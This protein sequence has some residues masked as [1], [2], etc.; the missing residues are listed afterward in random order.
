MKQRAKRLMAL[1]MA[2][3]FALSTCMTSGPYTV[4]ATEAGTAGVTTPSE[5]T[6]TTPSQGSTTT[7]D[8]TTPSGTPEEGGTTDP[9]PEAPTQHIYNVKL[10]EKIKDVDW[11][12]LQ[13]TYG[14]EKVSVTA[15]NTIALN[16]VITDSSAV[17]IKSDNYSFADITV[18]DGTIN[19]A[20]ATPKLSN[21][22]VKGERTTLSIDEK[23]EYS[24]SNI[25][26]VWKDK[27]T[28]SV[29]PGAEN[30]TTDGVSLEEQEDHTKIKVIVSKEGYEGANEK[31]EIL[32]AHIGEV[33]IGTFNFNVTKKNPELSLK[34]NP[35]PPAG[36][37]TEIKLL[38]SGQK[39][40]NKKVI[41]SDENGQTQEVAVK[42]GKAEEINWNLSY[43]TKDY[44]FVVTYAG[45]KVYKSESISLAYNVDKET[46]QFEL[47]QSAEQEDIT[48]GGSEK[49][50]ASIAGTKSSGIHPWNYSYEWENGNNG[51]AAIRVDG[52]KLLFTPGQAGTYKVTI[53][54]SSEDYN[55]CSCTLA[56]TVKKKALTVKNVTATNRVY[57][58]TDKVEVTAAVDTSEI[59]EKDRPAGESL[60]LTT[61][62]KVQGDGK[63]EGKDVADGKT[64]KYG[65]E[66]KDEYGQEYGDFSL[67]QELNSNYEL[68]YAD[69]KKPDVKVNIT[70]QKLTLAVVLAKPNGENN[71]KE[72]ETEEKIL[73][74]ERQ[75]TGYK[76][77][78]KENKSKEIQVV[79]T[80]FVNGES[81]ETLT[82]YQAPRVIV[83][84]TVITSASELNHVYKDALIPDENKTDDNLYNATD[85]YEFDFGNITQ[86]GSLS[87]TPQK[88]ADI[89]AILSVDNANSK[90]AYQR[91]DNKEIYYGEISES[92]NDNPKIAWKIDNQF[93]SNV[94]DTSDLDVTYNAVEVRHQIDIDISE[95]GASLSYSPKKNDETIYVRLKASEGN[96]VTEW[97]SLKLCF[98]ETV[99]KAKITME[100]KT[101]MYKFENVI[102]FGLFV[103]KKKS[104]SAKIDLTDEEAGVKSWKYYKLNLTEDKEFA[105]GK[106]FIDYVKN[107]LPTETGSTTT[108]ESSVTPEPLNLG[109]DEGNYVVFAVVEDNVGNEA[110]Y[111]SNGVIIDNT[112]PQ[113]FELLY[114]GLESE[115]I[116]N[117]ENEALKNVDFIKNKNA[118]SL[119][120]H[121]KEAT[122]VFSGISKIT[123]NVYAENKEIDK[124]KVLYE[125][126]NDTA[127]TLNALKNY[128][129]VFTNSTDNGKI[130]QKIASK[131]ECVRYRVDAT[132]G[133]K[134]GNEQTISKEF[135]LDTLPPDITN[136]NIYLTNNSTEAVKTMGDDENV[137]YYSNEDVTIKTTV[138]ERFTDSNNIWLT[139][140]KD[141]VE[142]S[143]TLQQWIDNDD[144]DETYSVT[145]EEDKDESN[146]NASNR[147]IEFTVQADGLENKFSYYVSAKDYSGN[148]TTND[149]INFVID[150]VSPEISDNIIRKS[151]EDQKNNEDHFDNKA[152]INTKVYYSNED[153]V[154][155][156]EVKDRFIDAK[157]IT[158]SLTKD[159]KEY[160]K[161]VEEWCENKD[162]KL[163]IKCTYDDP[164]KNKA[165]RSVKTITFN[166]PE[167]KNEGDFTYKVSAVDYANNPEKNPNQTIN[168]CID[169]TQPEVEVTYSPIQNGEPLAPINTSNS[170]Y[171][172]NQNYDSFKVNI[173]V[174]E[175]HLKANDKGTIISNYQLSKDLAINTYHVTGD[176]G[177]KDIKNV[178]VSASRKGSDS[179]VDL[180]TGI[181]ADIAGKESWLENP[182]NS[183]EY[184][185]TFTCKKE[186]NYE[187]PDITITDLAGN[188]SEATG[189]AKITLD[190][191]AP[192]GKIKVDGLIST[193]GK[194]TV[195]DRLL[196]SLTFGLYGKDPVTATIRNRDEKTGGSGIA[197]K[198]Y[199]LATDLMSRSALDALKD[200]QWTT[201]NGNITMPA[202][203]SY[204]VYEKVVDKAGNLAYYSSDRVIVD[205]QN[206]QPEV[207]ITPTTPGWG[208]GVYSASDNPGFD[209][210]V[211]DPAGSDG[212]CA[213][214]AEINCTITDRTTGHSKPI[215]LRSYSATSAPEATF[216]T[217]VSIDPA[218][219]YSNEVQV[220][221]EAK[222]HSTNPAT[223]ESQVIKIDN[224]API[225][226]FSFDKSDVHNG[227]YYNNDKTLTITVDERNFD[228]S[229]KPQV[230]STAGGGYSI[231]GWSHNGEI[232]T[233]TVTF[234]GDSDYTVTYD[235]YDLAGNKSNT[236]KLEEFT[237]DKTKPAIQV[238]Y[239]NNNAL[240]NNYYKDA[241]TATITITEHNF[242]PGEVTV[243]TTAQLDGAP[244]A[245]P[246]VSGWSG[247]GDTHVATVSY[248]A[249]ADYTFTISATDLA[250]NVSE[251]YVTD[252]FTVDQTKPTV[253]ITNIEDHSANNGEVAP[254]VTLN[255]INFD[256]SKT[257][258]HLTGANKGEIDTTGMYTSAATAKGQTLTFHNFAENMDDIYTLTAEAT[259]KAGNVYSTSK[260]FSVNRDGSTYMYDSYTDELIKNG[261][262]NDPKNLVVSEINVDTLTFQELT[263]TENGT[264][265]TLEQDK[266]Y[267]VQ[268]SGSEVS[269][270]EYKYTINASNFEEEGDYNVSIYSEDRA[271]NVT[272]NTSKSK[273]ILFAVDKTS[274]VIAL[275]NIEDGGRYKVESQKF[276]ANVDDN[277]A[278]DKVEYY[279]DGKLQQTFD[280]SEVAEQ[281][282]SL[283]LS[284]DSSSKF[285]K[286][287]VKAY[288]KANN[289]ATSADADVLVSASSWVQFYNN[290]PAFYGT[291]GGGVA[292]LA[293]AVAAGVHFSGA[294]AAAGTAGAAGAGGFFF[295]AGK[296]KKDE[297]ETK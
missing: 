18:N 193:N 214:L 48:Y 206:P 38:V 165:E 269:W 161:S 76:D 179:A 291:I 212:S 242:N 255:D 62:G 149:A 282:G 258:V 40:F 180:K 202:N 295:L 93:N 41:V 116:N 123:A 141:G 32:V 95:E 79:A 19:V 77:L 127:L 137:T 294:G 187:F 249:D 153:V 205:A 30:I 155:K 199:Y 104:V 55:E 241:R 213:G 264:L 188:K 223:V 276:T 136:N 128:E 208:K 246:G 174:I 297:E 34:A 70:K 240:N 271:T 105:D 279:V 7:P 10:P 12:N 49:Q 178:E 267:E 270:K 173:K 159:K 112:E 182:K 216:R 254:V 103:N 110:V 163:G 158:I 166:V 152:D 172:L 239:D 181:I 167:A 162:S 108:A 275:S 138:T 260:M 224:K 3:V 160:T 20:T 23:A 5:G 139:I 146:P 281:S 278:L 238:S 60:Q 252:N 229:Y 215:P 218:E 266:D 111:G 221:V 126:E 289:E 91:T 170:I 101:N 14:E 114:E 8:N 74:L 24:I 97:C 122:T 11:G 194:D 99:P 248:S 2:G 100:D 265:K 168:F 228:E 87:L 21:P 133:D 118:V 233:A 125:E 120:A 85:N 71:I 234:S 107:V 28:W 129:E 261:Y 13:V 184:N 175:K 169:T 113:I 43:W 200:E 45:D 83:D 292:V 142:T 22:E 115:D 210:Y 9:E 156:T 201:Y 25:P 253:E 185:Y 27:V 236:E 72:T 134:A 37:K 183:I 82:G 196:E 189:N 52:E 59:L 17:G 75:Y 106:A 96:G 6:P 176:I 257:V 89:K 148:E 171:Y 66:Y 109:T 73:Y 287:S 46:Q 124:G 58:G 198:S 80:G 231:S 81:A 211:V 4:M 119:Y 285:Q 147:T 222:D 33:Q 1:F 237:V 284:V 84:T 65:D 274:P 90:K 42:N 288:D 219:F 251:P 68:V 262:T 50:I 209:V 88:I 143:K 256:S 86:K 204:I 235:C 207:T 132:V 78:S 247:S 217:H 144:K 150:N 92:E 177:S 245:A 63:L 29:Q 225:V 286:V 296:K 154:V 186:A 203:R 57:D 31:P 94:K 164:D 61:A 250:S 232:H 280:A 277:M 140:V 273:D 263:V 290:K 47:T 283:E 197:K 131:G 244:V 26:D 272:T 135:V 64:V 54:R 192:E 226:T 157:H 130:E 39:D 16:N 117:P 268:E 243:T 190:R 51:G 67:S 259:D 44:K 98:D 102:T 53:K 15:E 151:I 56:I 227:K 35:E 36:W 293:A 145:V 121:A 230:T 195:W 220:T 191:T 69:N